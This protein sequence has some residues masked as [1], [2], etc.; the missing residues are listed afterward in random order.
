MRLPLALVL[1][2]KCSRFNAAGDQPLFTRVIYTLAKY[3]L[4]VP[5]SSELIADNTAGLMA[6]LARW[7]A[8]REGCNYRKYS[9]DWPVG[10]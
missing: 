3:G 1:L 7:F 9:A 5:V 2:V 10:C 8:K 6:Y 4:I